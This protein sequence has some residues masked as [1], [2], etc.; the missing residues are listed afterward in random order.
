MDFK[1]HAVKSLERINGENPEFLKK[2]WAKISP[3]IWQVHYWFDEFYN[4]PPYDNPY[5]LFYHRE[6]RHHWDG[7]RQAVEI[8]SAKYGEEFRDIIRQAGEDH[9]RQDYF[10]DIPGSREEC[11]RRLLRSMRGW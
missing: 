1:D 11:S 9:M 6:V 7:I 4:Q 2:H 10:Q 8:Y 3:M 5:T